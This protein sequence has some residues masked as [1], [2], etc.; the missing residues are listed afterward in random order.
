VRLAPE[1][2][3]ALRRLGTMQAQLEQHEAAVATYRRLLELAPDDWQAH[4]N[5][6]LLLQAREPAAALEHALRAYELKPD[7]VQVRVNLA[8]AYAVNGRTAEALAAYRQIEQA[9]PADDPLRPV[10]RERIE[11]L[12]RGR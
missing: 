6:T 4:T 10:L 11:G 8:G 3:E 12:E 5:L 9:V 2:V 1:N 7:S